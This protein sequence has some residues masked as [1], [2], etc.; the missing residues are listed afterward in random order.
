[1]IWVK[2]LFDSVYF[3]FED[4]YIG[5]AHDITCR[6]YAEKMYFVSCNWAYVGKECL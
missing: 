3:L 2:F 6:E 4:K 1:M 5:C